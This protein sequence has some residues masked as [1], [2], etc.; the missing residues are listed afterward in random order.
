MEQPRCKGCGQ[1]LLGGYIVAL[2]AT[3]HPE[4]F[5]CTGCGRPIGHAHFQLHQDHPYHAEC[6]AQMVAPRCA[7]CNKPL[8]G[9][10]RKDMWG[11]L[12]CEE[13]EAQYPPCA[14]CGR[15]IPPAQHEQDAEQI[16]CAICRSTAIE[17]VDV[18]R[19]VFRKLVQWAN[20]Q[21]L[22]YNNLP[23]SLELCGP[24]TLAKHLNETE[25][26]HSLGATMSETTYSPYNH[27]S[28]TT[29]T[30][31]AV[32]RGMPSTLFESV[33]L[34]ELGHVWLIVQGVL[35]LPRWANEGF[36]EL[37]S[38]RYCQ[39][40]NTPEGR[41]YA[42]AIERKSDPIYGEGFRRVRAIAERVGWPRLIETLQTTKRLPAA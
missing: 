28:Q 8:L 9:R 39:Q 3:W 41:Y 14:F 16:R 24:V 27:Y 40:L 26:G 34:H 12:Y 18:A 25:T 29:V 7:Y 32:L 10:Y 33:T 1:P 19:P 13:H 20:S 23:L 17:T 11:T 15:L 30:G 31:V 5:V 36:C 22:R 4:H 38:H 6:Y 2:G 37:L 35:G 21:G 42:E